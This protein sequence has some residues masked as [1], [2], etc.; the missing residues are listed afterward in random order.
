VGSIRVSSGIGMTWT[1]PF[2]PIRL[3][4]ARAI[5]KEDRDRTQFFSFSFG[6]RF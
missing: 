5:V 6:T 1:S 3:D 4:L 2:G